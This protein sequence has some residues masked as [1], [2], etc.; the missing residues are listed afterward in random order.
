MGLLDELLGAAGVGEAMPEAPLGDKHEAMAQAVTEMIAQQG[1]GGLE[2]MVQGF[3]QGGFGDLVSSWIGGGPNLPAQPEHVEQALGGDVL[4][5]L[6]RKVGVS[7]QVA[8]AL[9]AVVLPLV[10]NRLTPHGRIPAQNDLGGLLGG[11]LGGRSSGGLGGLGG[12]LGGL[13]GGKE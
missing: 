5:Q 7:P 3:H 11:L 6:A 1:T 8:S 2:S 10:I 9:L 12:V 13:L 4:S